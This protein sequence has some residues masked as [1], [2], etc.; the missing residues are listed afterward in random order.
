[1][2]GDE[3]SVG[4]YAPA[5][6]SKIPPGNGRLLTNRPG[7]H[8]DVVGLELR[9]RG[10]WRSVRWE[11]WAAGT[12]WR[13]SIDDEEIA[14][15]DPTSTDGEPNRDGGAAAA[16]AGGFGRDL[17]VNARWSGGLAAQAPLPAGSTGYV[18]VHGREGFPV[19]Y[20]HVANAGDPTAGAK[21]VLV[22]PSLDTYRLP[23]LVELDLRLERVESPSLAQPREVLRP[24]LVR[25]GVTFEF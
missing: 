19:P 3:Y 12:E 20:I 21:N 8:Q 4:Y 18:F 16:R 1:L 14:V 10:R 5:S 9:L 2:F 17:F 15:M 6:A 13:E 23:A 22:S 7:Y 25:L 11:T 24:R